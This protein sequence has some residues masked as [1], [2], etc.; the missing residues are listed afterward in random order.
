LHGRGYQTR[1]RN[2]RLIQIW[3]EGSEWDK[4]HLTPRSKFQDNIKEGFKNEGASTYLTYDTK[5]T[6]EE[7]REYI[8]N[9]EK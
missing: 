8:T 5:H 2:K 3:G 7:M 1:G 9:G 4:T 6:L